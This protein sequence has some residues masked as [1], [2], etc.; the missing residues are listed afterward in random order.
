MAGPACIRQSTRLL[1][2]LAKSVPNRADGREHGRPPGAQAKCVNAIAIVKH[3]N[4]A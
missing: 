2:C 4:R 3:I 1:L